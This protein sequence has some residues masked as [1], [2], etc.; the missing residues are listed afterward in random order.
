MGSSI[1]STSLCSG[2]EMSVPNL[3]LS[4]GKHLPESVVLRRKNAVKELLIENRF[5][6][7]ENDNILN[8]Q[9]IVSIEPPYDEE[10]CI[11]TNEI[12]LLRI[13]Q[14]ISNIDV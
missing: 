4:S 9:G 10:H 1:E 14:L 2:P 5:P 6:V 8:I 3:F 11:S 12:V 7:E 13:Q